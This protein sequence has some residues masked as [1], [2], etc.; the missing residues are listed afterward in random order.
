MLYG[1][2]NPSRLQYNL[3][4][5]QSLIAA[6]EIL[7]TEDRIADQ[8]SSIKKQLRDAGCPIPENDIWIAAICLFHDIPLFSRDSHFDF[9]VG[10]SRF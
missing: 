7:N 8:Y 1:A 6:C 10:L 3:P 4:R 2:K 5:Y 9:V